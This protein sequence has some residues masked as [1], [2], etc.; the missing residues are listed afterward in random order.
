M[1]RESVSGFQKMMG[2]LE[3]IVKKFAVTTS[4]GHDVEWTVQLRPKGHYALQAAEKI[5][6]DGKMT[7]ARGGSL[8]KKY[9]ALALTT[10]RN[11][12]RAGRELD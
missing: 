10:V 6:G 4:H 5:D 3:V 8:P 9:N 12:L 2:D 1:A 7:V 11:W